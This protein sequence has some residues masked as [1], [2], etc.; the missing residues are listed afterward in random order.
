MSSID[1]HPLARAGGIQPTPIETDDPFGRLDGLMQV[2]EALCPTYPQRD[3]FTDT[4][5]FK[6]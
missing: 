2:I 4:G 1:P 6:L 5:R 3:I